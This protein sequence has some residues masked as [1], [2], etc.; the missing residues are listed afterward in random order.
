MVTEAKHHF[1]IA[2]AKV[3]YSFDTAKYFCNFFITFLLFCLFITRPPPIFHLSIAIIVYTDIYSLR[4]TYVKRDNE[5]TK[6]K[7]NNEAFLQETLFLC[8]FA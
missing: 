7:K 8:K 4:A 2:G 3:A 6:A 5:G 1:L